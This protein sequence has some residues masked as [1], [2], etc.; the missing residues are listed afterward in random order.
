MSYFLEKTAKYL[1][2]RYGEASGNLC[3]VMPNRRGG[4]F[5]REY[6]SGIISQPQWT[7]SVYAIEDFVSELAGLQL[8]DNF[9][10]LFTLYTVYRKHKGKN[11]ESFESFSRWAPSLLADFNEADSWMADTR[12]LFGN[13]GHLKNLEGWSTDPEQLTGFQQQYAG[14]WK[15]LGYYYEQFG[16]ELKQQQK[17]YPGLAYRQVAGDILNLVGTR[18][19]EKIIFCGFNALNAAEEKIISELLAAGKA[20]V[21]FDRDSYYMR[22]ESQE[23]GLFLRNYLKRFPDNVIAPGFEHETDELATAEKEIRIIGTARRTSQVQAASW[24]LQQWVKEPGHIPKKTAVVTSDE[25]LLLPLLHALPDSSDDVNVTMGYPM[26]NTPI[27]ALASN[28]LEMHTEAQKHQQQTPDGLLRFYHTDVNRLLSHPYI[29]LL[30][31]NTDAGYPGRLA[32]YLAENNFVFVSLKQL[33]EALPESGSSFRRIAPLFRTWRTTQD[34]FYSIEYLVGVLRKQFTPQRRENEKRKPSVELEFLFQFDKL[35][36]RLRSLASQYPHLRELKTLRALLLQAVDSTSLP[37]Y[38]EPLTGLQ[39]MGLLETRTLDFDNVI[40][41]SCN[42]NKLPPARN[43]GT[44]IT[45]ALRREFNLPGWNDKDAVTAYHFY[46]LLQRA[47]RIVLVYNTETDTFGKGEKSRYLTQIQYELARAN[48]NIKVTEELFSAPAQPP[49]VSEIRIE[50]TEQIIQKLEELAAGGLSPSLLNSYRTC[51]MQFYYRYVAGIRENDRVEETIGADTM[52]IVIHATLEQLYL[53]YKGQQLTPEHV[54]EMYTHLRG[55]IHKEFALRY[56]VE[57][58]QYGKNLLIQHITLKYLNDFLELEMETAKRLEKTKQRWIIH[59][60]ETELKSAVT[61]GARTIQL[62]G[63][64]DRI[65]EIGSTVRIIDYKTG[66][67]KE[68]ELKVSNWFDFNTNYELNKSFQL[69]MYAYMYERSGQQQGR[70]LQSGIIT[71]RK[72][73]DGLKTVKTIAENT[74]LGK[75]DLNTFEGLLRDMLTEL[76]APEIDFVQTD[77]V[78]RCKICPYR[79]VCNRG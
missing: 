78:E 28:L 10:Q 2:A 18:P 41:L 16:E 42:E 53:P 1:C 60:L 8:V 3:V 21:L 74:H 22:E 9:E 54:E 39:V 25:H 62:K 65:D 37:F 77:D 32:N 33:Q 48:V 55:F 40:L 31:R 69:L 61:V 70:L 47:K 58:L 71:F 34:A 14:F 49:G 23:A 35:V 6:W 20:D 76:F 29:R 75:D 43:H 4:L 19:W 72:L 17:A 30:F 51:P 11:A 45:A 50:K 44:F 66:Q 5:L 27:A 7:P 56:P 13:V 12:R 26:R 59:D 67:V 63:H 15:S 57:E 64:A 79:E 24:F 73:K 38:G 68:P 46:R 36:S 52:G